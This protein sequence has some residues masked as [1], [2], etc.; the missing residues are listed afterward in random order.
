MIAASCYRNLSHSLVL[1]SKRA[2][3]L[4]EGAFD[5]VLVVFFGPMPRHDGGYMD[6]RSI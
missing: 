1:F 2:G 6:V 4:R 3:R 5:V